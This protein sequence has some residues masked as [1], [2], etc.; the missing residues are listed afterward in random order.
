MEKLRD[1]R[2]EARRILPFVY[3]GNTGEP[4]ITKCR[5]CGRDIV[6][7][8]GYTIFHNSL[9]TSGKC[10]HCGEDNGMIL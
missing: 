6:A 7:R 9:D 1:F 2:E 3:L 5:R 4:E 10:G 8:R